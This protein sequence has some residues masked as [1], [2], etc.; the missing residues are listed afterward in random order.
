MR[1]LLVASLLL[2]A[3]GPDDGGRDGFGASAPTS[4]T[5][6]TTAG[7]TTGEAT[8]GA[9]TTGEATTGAS[10]SG[11]ATT[12]SATTATTTATTG[13]L[14]TAGSTGGDG[15]TTA[16]ASTGGTTGPE[17]PTCPPMGPID[18]RP[19]PGSGEGDTCTKGESCFITIVQDAVKQVLSEHPEWFMK[20]DKGDYVLEVELYM[21][22]VVEVVGATPLCAIRD[23]NAG[24]EIAVKHD[25]EY[26]ENFDILTAEGYA[27]YGPLIYTST[28]APAWF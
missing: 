25:N 24:D 20:D 3:C 17:P 18:C 16:P 28:C 1:P 10:G 21:N 7:A 27:R 2:L 6:G 12:T 22:T 14:T 13:A 11:G 9:P 15:S 5:P 4:A 19:G 8:T 26:A 23:P